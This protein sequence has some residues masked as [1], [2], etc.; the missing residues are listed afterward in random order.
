MMKCNIKNVDITLSHKCFP[1]SYFDIIRTAFFQSSAEKSPWIKIY[2]MKNCLGT[3][4]FTCRMSSIIF[5]CDYIL[6][7]SQREQR[8]LGTEI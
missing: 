8:N 1:E 6:M 4:T 2:G 3:S 5:S 7:S